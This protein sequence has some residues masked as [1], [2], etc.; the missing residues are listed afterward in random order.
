MYELFLTNEA[1]H[2]YEEADPVLVRKLNLCSGACGMIRIG[3]E[4][5]RA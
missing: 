2:F 5:Q 1:H 3:P 4:R